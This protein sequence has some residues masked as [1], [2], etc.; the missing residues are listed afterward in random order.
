M[1]RIAIT[2]ANVAG[3]AL[4]TFF[5]WLQR[6]DDNPDVYVNPSAVD[7]WTWI[8]FY[9]LVAVLFGLALLRRFPW[10][11]YA[12]AGSLC[13]YEFVMTGPGLISNLTSGHFNMTKEGMSPAHGEV[14]LTREFFGAVIALAAC[15]FL[16]WQRGRRQPQVETG[17][18]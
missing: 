3:L 1:N 16:W 2:I 14:E 4:F 7:T 15:S 9:G 6:E 10:P 5:A 12:L 11:L 18:P 13:L 17:R 8:I